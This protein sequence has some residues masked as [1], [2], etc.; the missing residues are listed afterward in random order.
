MFSGRVETSSEDLSQ[1]EFALELG[2]LASAFLKIYKAQERSR[3]AL[4][5]T[6]LTQRL[7]ILSFKDEPSLSMHQLSAAVGLAGSTMTR[8]VDR[9][10]A[11]GLARRFVSDEDRRQVCVELTEKGRRTLQKLKDIQLRFFVDLLQEIP[12]EER[13]M[14]HGAIKTL[15]RVLYRRTPR[16]FLQGF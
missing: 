7:T 1:V 5:G 2:R 16:E 12:S 9:L 6:T 3:A 10:V 15:N 11:K 14:M 8:V 13:G 4:Y